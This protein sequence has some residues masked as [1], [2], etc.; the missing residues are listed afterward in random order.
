MGFCIMLFPLPSMTFLVISVT[1]LK[2]VYI[3]K[4]TRI[5]A[6]VGCMYGL[7]LCVYASLC[8][9]VSIY[10]LHNIEDWWHA[11]HSFIPLG[12]RKWQSSHRSEKTKNRI[13]PYRCYLRVIKKC[14]LVYT[15]LANITS[16][17]LLTVQGGGVTNDP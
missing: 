4:K 13:F 15:R 1:T 10:I 8:I 12:K 9:S 2:L 17:V 11:H 3:S 16:Y 6:S 5:F 14:G 7:Y